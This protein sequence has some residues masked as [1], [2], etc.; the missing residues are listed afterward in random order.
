MTFEVQSAALVSQPDKTASTEAGLTL[1]QR[2]GLKYQAKV[3]KE[4]D[5]LY[6]GLVLLRPWFWYKVDWKRKQC[7]PDAVLFNAAF[8]RCSALEIK[9]STIPEAWTKLS[10]LYA[11]VLQQA[12]P[13]PISICLI[14]R[15]FDPP[16]KFATELIQIEGL[17]RLGQCN[18]EGLGVVSWK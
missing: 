1:V 3:E 18:G 14:T 8:S 9:Y 16:L 13:I 4:L 7:Q 2:R 11:P 10:Q 5:R 12:Y 17:Q 15:A 6:S